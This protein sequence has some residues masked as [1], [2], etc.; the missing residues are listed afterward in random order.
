MDYDKYKSLQNT[1]SS[2]SDLPMF[3]PIVL[4]LFKK[5]YNLVTGYKTYPEFQTILQHFQ[6]FEFDGIKIYHYEAGEAPA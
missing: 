2:A 5:H 3:E 4:T 1:S 6:K